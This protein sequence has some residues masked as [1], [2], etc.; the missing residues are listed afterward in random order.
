MNNNTIKVIIT[1]V[2]GFLSSL[3]GI[4]YVPVLLL[5]A[6]NI[7]D[8]A[9]GI[10]ASKYR[11]QPVDSYKGFRGI[12]KKISMWLLVVVGAIV[13]QLLKYAAATIGITMPITFL[14][15]CVVAIWIICNE[16]ISILENIKDIGAPVPPF[17]LPLLKNLKSQVEEVAK[18][19]EKEKEDGTKETV[20]VEPSREKYKIL[21]RPVEWEETVHPACNW[22]LLCVSRWKTREL[23]A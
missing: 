1:A 6:C 22:H 23:R 9:T 15:A 8:Y 5:V 2:T 11:N 19:E 18:T 13:D 3:L 4:L 17:L 7:I 10:F 14:I 21:K 20:E 16:I 12:A